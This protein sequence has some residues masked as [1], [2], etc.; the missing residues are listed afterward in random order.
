MRVTTSG[1]YLIQ[2]TT[3]PRFFPVNC[4]LVREADGLTLIDTGM[5]GSEQAIIQAAEQSGSPI[6]RIVITHAHLDHVGALDALHRLLPEVEV[7]VSQREARLL[8]GDQRLDAPEPQAK[9]RGS[10]R[11]SA[12]R[13]QRLVND[14]DLIGSLRVISTP[15]HTPGQ[16]ALLDTRDQSLVAGDAL[17]T[18]GGVAVAGTLIW[19]FPFPAIATWQRDLALQSAQRLLS[20]EP[21]RLAVGHGDV[22]EQPHA[23]IRDAIEIAAQS[24][25]K[26]QTHGT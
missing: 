16:I 18:H 6:R 3:F 13:P 1:E 26:A 7:I 19:R 23:A 12:I 15:G 4:Y 17:Q 9:L 14:G 22:I 10:Y 5:P 24:L 25:R 20:L 11:T 2:L 8:A 21:A